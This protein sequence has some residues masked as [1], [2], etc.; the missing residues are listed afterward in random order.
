MEVIDDSPHHDDQKIIVSD[1]A[2]LAHGAILD[3]RQVADQFDD[4][5]EIH[6]ESKFH[7]A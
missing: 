4:L 6:R 7:C 1:V 5:L 3:L 2:D